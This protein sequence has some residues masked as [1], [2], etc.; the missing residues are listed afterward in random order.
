MV[1]FIASFLT[2]YFER[3]DV[4]VNVDHHIIENTMTATVTSSSIIDDTSFIFP[5]VF[6]NNNETLHMN[7]TS[8]TTTPAPL[9]FVHPH[10]TSDSNNSNRRGVDGQRPRS[11]TVGGG[12]GVNEEKIATNTF[13]HRAASGPIRGFMTGT[14]TGASSLFPKRRTSLLRKCSSTPDLLICD[15]DHDIIIDDISDDSEDEEETSE[16]EE[17]AEFVEHGGGDNN[18]ESFE[19]LSNKAMNEEE[20]EEEDEFTEVGV[21]NDDDDYSEI[22]PPSIN[23]SSCW[24]M[25]STLLPPSSSAASVAWGCTT[26]GPTF[27][28]V[29]LARQRINSSDE[30]GEF[31]KD[32]AITEAKLLDP[33]RRNHHLRIRIKPKLVVVD[34]DGSNSHGTKTM[35]HSHS[36]GGLSKMLHDVGEGHDSS[37]GQGGRNR[38]VKKKQMRLT[39]MEEDENCDIVIGRGSGGGIAADGCGGGGPVIGE[40]DAMDYYQRK[41]HGSK[42][43]VNKKKERPD[44]AKRREIIMYKKNLQRLKQAESQKGQKV[45]SSSTKEMK[46]TKNDK[47]VG[48]KKEKRRL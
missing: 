17:D 11:Y 36:T 44:E 9:A 13:F 32:K 5:D 3:V 7:T 28:D 10:N 1:I 6:A 8:T 26:S 25:A 19:V 33:N 12:G 18:N 20:E 16:E 22:A 30:E 14:A 45:E 47:G 35:K 23:T 48:G 34:D 41:E 39:I 46:K 4:I 42:S 15:N 21:E 37:F 24:S 27:K 38:R 2:L 29:L 31:G 40:S 43:T